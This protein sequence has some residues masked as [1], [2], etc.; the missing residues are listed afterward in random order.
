MGVDFGR[1]KTGVEPILKNKIFSDGFKDLT[2]SPKLK[3]DG[4]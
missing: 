4:P 1:K 3:V 2:T